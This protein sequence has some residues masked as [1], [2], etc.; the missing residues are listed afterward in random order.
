MRILKLNYAYI[1]ISA[2]H[3][4]L[5]QFIYIVWFLTGRGK[6]VRGYD[7]EKVVRDYF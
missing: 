1:N 5:V 3:N 2:G 7:N 6:H 4:M